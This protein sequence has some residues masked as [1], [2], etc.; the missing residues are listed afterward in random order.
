MGRR[1]DQW[2][3]K[4][5]PLA[6]RLRTGVA[7]LDPVPAALLRKYIAYARQHVPKL[8]DA[9]RGVL[10][11]FYIELRKC[12]R[13]A[14]RC[15]SRRGSS[16]RSSAS[17]RQRAAG[18]RVEVTAG[19]AHDAIEVVKDTIFF[20]EIASLMG[21]AAAPTWAWLRHSARFFQAR[22][23]RYVK[24]LN[25]EAESAASS[26]TTDE[27]ERASSAPASRTRAS[28]ADLIE[29]LNLENYSKEGS[30]PVQAPDERRLA[31]SLSRRGDGER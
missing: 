18:L 26:F 8:S 12:T 24:A 2:R 9:A 31:A 30:W 17:P 6:T 25:E 22:H 21:G 11:T 29:Q 20:D 4:Q 27:L 1:A 15:Q 19:D 13:A 28:F 16:N 14:T 23:P 3:R 10:C 7:Q 5:E